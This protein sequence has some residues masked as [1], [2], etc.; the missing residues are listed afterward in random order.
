MTINFTCQHCKMGKPK[1]S[2]WWFIDVDVAMYC[3]HCKA[4]LAHVTFMLTAILSAISI[5][6]VYFAIQDSCTNWLQVKIMLSVS[7]LPAFIFINATRI[8]LLWILVWLK[9]TN[10]PLFSDP[11]D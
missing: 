2:K 3:N 5:T 6:T 8:G 4:R 10:F 1:L 11:K 7:F 9:Q